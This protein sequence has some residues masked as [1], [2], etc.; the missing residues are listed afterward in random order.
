VA[1]ETTQVDAPEEEAEHSITELLEQLGR[2]VAALAYYESRLAASRNQE[3]LRRVGRDALAAL[4][5]AAAL[6]TVFVFANTAALLALSTAMDAWLAALVLAA[7]WT[8]IGALLALTLWLRLRRAGQAEG[9]SVE[10]AR[11]R[12]EH[13]VRAT[14]EQL[15]PT[16]TKE[17]A[18]AAVPSAGGL[19]EMGDDLI[20]EADEIVDSITDE[21][22]GGGVVNQVWDVVLAPGRFGIRVATTVL[23]RGES[24]S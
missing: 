17:I 21:L 11:D 18:L 9:E 19:V 3:T 24:N 10:E 7:A 22:P 5:A 2:D 16:I 4:A 1:E 12:A 14:L 8:A 6:L 23:K 15:A 13:A 20:E